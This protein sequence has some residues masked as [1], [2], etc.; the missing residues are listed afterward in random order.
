VD[1]SLDGP[2]AVHD[3]IRGVRGSFDRAVE[4][5]SVLNELKTGHGNLDV[6]II[7]TVSARNQDCIGETADLVER[8]HPRGE[9]MVNVVRGDP[10]EPEVAGVEP[11]RYFEAHRIIDRRMASGL[12]TGHGGHPGAG[13]LTAKNATRRK[14]IRRTLEGEC[15]GGGCAAGCLGG[16]VHSEGT[17]MPC[18]MLDRPMGNLR[19]F[20]FDLGRMWNSPRADGIRDWIQESRCLCTQEC[21]LSVSLLIQPRHWPDIVRERIRLA[22]SRR[23]RHRAC[24]T[25]EGG[26]AV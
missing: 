5:I 4:S 6:G 2:A 21:F 11:D 9:W 3:D 22:G 26:A 19:D 14:I 12:Y 7:T 18:E 8:I 24:T 16:V 15:R 13:W 25:T 20:D 23:R 10:R 17:V 1:V